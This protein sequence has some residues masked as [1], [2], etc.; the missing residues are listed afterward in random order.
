MKFSFDSD[1]LMKSYESPDNELKL[2][3]ISP[4]RDSVR[5]DYN[6]HVRILQVCWD[7][8]DV[9]TRVRD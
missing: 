1:I 6:R 3:W 7:Q 8:G 5:V 2:K 9:H 4:G